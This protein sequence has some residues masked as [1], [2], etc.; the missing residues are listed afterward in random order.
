MLSVDLRRAV[1]IA[2]CVL[3]LGAPASAQ[4]FATCPAQP[5]AQVFLPWGDPSWYTLVPDGGM[6][7]RAGAWRPGGAAAFVNGN[8]SFYVRSRGDQWALRLPAGAAG[9]SAPTC[10][11][12]GHPTLRLFVRNTGAATARLQ[13][14]VEFV[15]LAGIRRS[16]PVAL[17]KGTSAWAPTPILPILVN[18]TSPAS[19]QQVAFR[20]TPAGGDWQIDDVYLDP[21]GKG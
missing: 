18:A 11:Q 8:E 4:A 21:Y 17:L 6:E 16:T 2:V 3:L 12:L 7:T 5:S 1:L 19:A 20:F 15:D 13:V 10:I 14:A 9:S